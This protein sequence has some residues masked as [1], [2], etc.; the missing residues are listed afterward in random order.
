MPHEDV[1][2]IHNIISGMRQDFNHHGPRVAGNVVKLAEAVGM[3][4]YEIGLISAA[5]HLHDIGKLFIRPELLNKPGALTVDERAEMETHV[6]L[7]WALVNQAG[8]E[9]IIQDVIRHH[10]EKWDGTGYPD[11]LKAEDI[12]LSARIVTVCDI[13]QAMTDE[14]VYRKAETHE[15]TKEFMLASKGI[16]L[17]PALTDLFFEKVVT[18]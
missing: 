6:P 17:D 18:E 1:R 4:S 14:R 16:I 11:G 3:S 15:F 9:K 12:P 7:G 10:H 2:L 5:A 8:Y 13:Y